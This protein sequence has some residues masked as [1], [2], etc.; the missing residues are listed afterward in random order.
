[1]SI[2]FL[3]KSFKRRKTKVFLTVLAI[4]VGVISVVIISAVGSVGK[5]IIKNEMSALG[6]NGLVVSKNIDLETLSLSKY[7]LEEIKSLKIVEN[8]SPLIYNTSTVTI[9]NKQSYCI[10]FGADSKNND[11]MKLSVVSGRDF[12]PQ[13]I[14]SS[15]NVCLI[16]EGFALSSFGT[17]NVVNKS[18][19]I[20]FGDNTQSFKIVGVISSKNSM[21]KNMLSQ[22]TLNFIYLPY[23][24]LMQFS[25][26]ENFDSITVELKDNTNAS[27]AETTLLKQLSFMSGIDDA[28]K[29]ENMH[30]HSDSL[31]KILNVVTLVLSLIAGVSLIVSGISVMTSML[32]SVR[33]RT[34]EI[35][36]KKSVGARSVDIMAEF[37]F[38]A[39]LISLLGLVLGLCLGLLISFI[40]ASALS[41]KLN[42]DLN[43]I[44]SCV[45]ITLFSGVVFGAYP[46]VCACKLKP[47]DALKFQ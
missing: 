9:N 38:E 19:L 43:I 23:T 29:I 34:H 15:N 21:V 14:T 40:A 41:V 5:S 25:Q 6:L 20:T 2:L 45:I 13:D 36:I 30:K 4:S 16:D 39:F 47:I 3:L 37:L 8:A 17:K 10:L 1:M 32:S 12:Y 26:N 42:F 24:T 28:Y 35:G 33:E 22:Y 31:N 7:E 46:A 27:L 11:T 44:I 18:L